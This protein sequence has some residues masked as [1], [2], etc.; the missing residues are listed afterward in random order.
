MKI[1]RIDRFAFGAFGTFGRMSAWD[2]DEERASCYS[3]EPP[4]FPWV[5]ENARDVSCI[6]VGTYK[7]ERGVYH[8]NTAD[9][10][11]DYPCLVVPDGEVPDRGPGVKIHAGNLLKHTLACPLTGERIGFLGTSPA[12]L[13]SRKAL[14]K[15]LEAFGTGED[16]RL[17]VR[18][19]RP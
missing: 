6:P 2:D 14:A 12:V 17:E 1:V 13:S 8:R 10:A 3:L 19:L 7:L 16:G 11:D 5:P 4:P 15:I 9:T 18:E